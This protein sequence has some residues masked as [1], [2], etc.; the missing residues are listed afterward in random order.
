MIKGS[1]PKLKSR[2]LSHLKRYN[3]CSP[4]STHHHFLVLLLLLLFSRSSVKPRTPSVLFLS[5]SPSPLP[6]AFLQFWPGVMELTPANSTRTGK[7]WCDDRDRRKRWL[8]AV[9]TDLMR[10][11]FSLSSP[12]HLLLPPWPSTS[13]LQL[14][15]FA[16]LQSSEVVSPCMA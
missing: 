16:W 8:Q 11:L 5:L 14:P 6:E 1:F 9:H 3:I 2:S 10:A 7:S 12:H 13:S 15:V 4:H